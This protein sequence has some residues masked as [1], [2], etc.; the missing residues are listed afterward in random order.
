[1]N[2][3][4]PVLKNEIEVK[5]V[6]TT[7]VENN[8]NEVKEF[9]LKLK[10]YY[11]KL[12]FTNEQ[13]KEAES[14]RAT[15]NKAIK[16]IS[17]YRKETISE[18][19]KPIELFEQ[20][21]KETEQILKETSD[22][23]DK[24]IKSYEEVQKE[25]RKVNAK[26]IYDANIEELKELIPFEKIFNEKWLNK[27]SW[28][29]D[30]TSSLIQNEIIEIREKVR[31]GLKTIESL[32][33]EFELELKNTFLQD[34]SLENAILKNNQLIEQ[35][36]AL[37][38]S[39]EVKEEIKVKKTEEFISKKVENE[40]LEPTITYTLKITGTMSQMKALRAFLETN[41]MDF[42]KVN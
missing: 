37:L 31:N 24:Q 29:D 14:E 16:K 30:N 13:I 36:K 3:E 23:V 18:F 32:N 38:K 41:E 6:G 34:F 9:A 42:E 11:S 25:K 35:Q 20:T 2:I 5:I 1:M 4:K 10:D 17:D 28:K 22:Y 15:I 39:N 12:I 21:A 7:T 27:G 40:D 19:K 8:I 26:K 33:S